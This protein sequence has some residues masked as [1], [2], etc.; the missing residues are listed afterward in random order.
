M[1][2]KNQQNIID[3][4]RLNWQNLNSN[5]ENACNRLIT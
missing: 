1:R 2:K 3:V 5:K 4:I